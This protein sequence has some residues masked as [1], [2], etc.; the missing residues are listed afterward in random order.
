VW[1]GQL[2]LVK[3]SC[4]AASETNSLVEYTHHGTKNKARTGGGGG[5]GG[6]ETISVEG[7][8]VSDDIS[9]R[10][11]SEIDLGMSSGISIIEL[12]SRMD[13]LKLDTLDG[14]LE[15]GCSSEEP[16]NQDD[17]LCTVGPDVS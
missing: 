6:K 15:S 12:E 11:G 3:G 13:D 10:E 16:G 17:G 8:E 1:T 5:G 4:E 9:G 2:N 7:N 14:I